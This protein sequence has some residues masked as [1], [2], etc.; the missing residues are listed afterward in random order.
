MK[1]E[2]LLYD[3]SRSFEEYSNL[4]NLRRRVQLH[5]EGAGAGAGGD[6]KEKKEKVRRFVQKC[7]FDRYI[8]PCKDVK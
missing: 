7:L 6:E 1:I 4:G 3:S 5:V 8:V 2:G